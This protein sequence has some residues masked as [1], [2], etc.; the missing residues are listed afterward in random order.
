MRNYVQPGNS[1]DLVA[2]AGGVTS[3]VG[4]KIGAIIA[5]AAVTA[6]AAA[7]FAGYVDGVFDAAADTGTAWA[8]GDVVYWDDTNKRFTK[9]ATANTKAGYAVAAKTSG[10]TVGRIA[11]VP[12]I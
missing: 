8:A 2:P 12:S 5:I 10:A 11:L 4:V 7:T 3:G 1:L 9:T 6:A